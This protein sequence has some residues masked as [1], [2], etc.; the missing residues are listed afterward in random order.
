[1]AFPLVT[2]VGFWVRLSRLVFVVHSRP[3]ADSRPSDGHFNL[4][5]Y[6]GF[7][8]Q[9]R[10]MSS[11]EQAQGAET[12]QVPA[13]TVVRTPAVRREAAVA[14]GATALGALALGAFAVGAVAI[15]KLA[16]GQL[17]LGRARLRSGRVGQLRIARLTIE[18]LRIERVLGER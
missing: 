8:H 4:R 17:A 11:C 3:V 9:E 7:T 6:A 18:E 2:G 13:A 5:Y 15:G 12:D 16:I 1:M 14:I 10:N